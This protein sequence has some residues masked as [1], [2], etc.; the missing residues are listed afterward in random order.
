MN[1]KFLISLT[2]IL[3]TGTILTLSVYALDFIGT[4]GPDII[5]GTDFDD[6]IYG[7]EGNDELYGEKGNDRLYGGLGNDLLVDYYGNNYLYGNEGN[8]ILSSEA[9]NYTSIHY[10]YGG[11][12]DDI[13]YGLVG[14]EHMYGGT[15][16]DEIYASYG[17]DFI[18]GGIGNDYCNGG[19]LNDR[20]EFYL[21]TSGSTN[22]DIIVDSNSFCSSPGPH[23]GHWDDGGFDI[24]R[25]HSDFSPSM[26][27]FKDGIDLIIKI[28]DKN[29]I[30]V[31][32]FFG[33]P[34]IIDDIH[35]LEPKSI[36]IVKFNDRVFDKGELASL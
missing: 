22:E 4:P 34:Q 7:K 6:S 32:N 1:R 33:P 18:N 36:E 16:N 3:I 15:G 26:T 13:L 8:D 35:S 5:H 28:D 19:P 2:T 10:L 17:D 31:V 14:S 24:I 20:Y 25:I 29:K 9:M 27:P 11:T 12:G 21:D 23:Y 30:T